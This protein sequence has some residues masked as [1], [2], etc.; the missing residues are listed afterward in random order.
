MRLKWKLFS[1]S[2]FYG[3]SDPI[4]ELTIYDLILGPKRS[5]PVLKD[6][7]LTPDSLP[8]RLKNRTFELF[9][10]ISSLRHAIF[11]W[12][13]LF[14]GVMIFATF[15]SKIFNIDTHNSHI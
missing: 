12:A 13:A 9:N 5:G 4:F 7:D 2:F 15:T 3:A 6:L 11:G 10:G 14:H 8:D 1:N